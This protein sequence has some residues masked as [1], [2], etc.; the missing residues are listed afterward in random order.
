MYYF[1]ICLWTHRLQQS[2]F[3]VVVVV[4][5]YDSYSYI[6][7]DMGA[8]VIYKHISTYLDMIILP[9][10]V[11]RHYKI[12]LFI[13]DGVTWCGFQYSWA[14]FMAEVCYTEFF[15]LVWTFLTSVIQIFSNVLYI[16]TINSVFSSSIGFFCKVYS[17]YGSRFILI[18]KYF[19]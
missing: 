19:Y 18:E 9:V 13:W 4:A 16:S 7:N 15:Q 12:R 8:I 11:S 10:I 6:M 2:I 5:G 1:I 14:N 3:Y 17:N